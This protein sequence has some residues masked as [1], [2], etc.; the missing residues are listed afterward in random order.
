MA[1]P[2]FLFFKTMKNT[3]FINQ[4]L[5]SKRNHFFKNLVYTIVVMDISHIQ[6]KFL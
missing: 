3:K 2:I 4:K 6:G 5:K 1:D